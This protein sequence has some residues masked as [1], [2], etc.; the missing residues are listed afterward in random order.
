MNPQVVVACRDEGPGLFGKGLRLL[1]LRWR[2]HPRPLQRT[3][4]ALFS[5][6]FRSGLNV[7]FGE[8]LV[9]YLELAFPLRRI[10]VCQEK[11]SQPI[12]SA[13]N[14]IIIACGVDC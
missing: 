12:V 1:H 4:L 3:S 11:S 2:R 10:S 6:K 13:L 7:A 14:C 9:G 8:Q 5:A